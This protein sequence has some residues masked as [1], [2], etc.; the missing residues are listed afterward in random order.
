VALAGGLAYFSLPVAP[1]PQVEFP[2]IQVSAGLPGAG[3][4][5]MASSVAPRVARPW[6]EPGTHGVFGGHTA[7]AAVRPNSRNYRDDVDEQPRLDADRAP[8]RS[9][10]E[11]RCGGFARSRARPRRTHT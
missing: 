6:A 4:E 8:V 7:R 2:T 10:S 3:P 5:T 9:R 11:H 1:L